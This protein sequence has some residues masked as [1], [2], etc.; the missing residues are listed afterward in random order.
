MKLIIV[1]LIIGGSIQ[2]FQCNL[3]YCSVKHEKITMNYLS[4]LTKI[5]LVMLLFSL[6]SCATPLAPT[7][8][9]TDKE[10]PSIIRTV[11]QNLRTGVNSQRVEI[12]FSEY[13]NRNS[14][15]SN[16]QIEPDIGIDYRLSWKKKTF[17]MWMYPSSPAWRLILLRT[18]RKLGLYFS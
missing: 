8:G 12:E 16:L 9:P 7:G 1:E 4:G 5:C 14:L 15:S 2:N 13:V 10:G 17:T 11:P 18:W 3:L 6:L